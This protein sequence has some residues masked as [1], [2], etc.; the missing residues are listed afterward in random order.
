MRYPASKLSQDDV[1]DIR[2]RAAS[3]EKFEAIA[4]SY[5]I[6]RCTISRIATG[7]AWKLTEGPR[8]KRTAVIQSLV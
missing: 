7:K 5:S 2:I 8:T 3:G 6:T 1:I 4:S